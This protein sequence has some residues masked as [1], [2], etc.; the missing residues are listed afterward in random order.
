MSTVGAVKEARNG[1]VQVSYR[2]RKV[3]KS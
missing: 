1:R 3:N 2:G